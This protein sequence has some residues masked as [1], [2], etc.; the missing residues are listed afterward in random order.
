MKTLAEMIKANGKLERRVNVK[1]VSNLKIIGSNE[2][3]TQDATCEY[4]G[5][6]FTVEI[7]G[8]YITHV[9]SA[10]EI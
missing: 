10:E 7:K 9:Y 2:Y 3:N 6:I 8:N 1:R 5:Y 4:K